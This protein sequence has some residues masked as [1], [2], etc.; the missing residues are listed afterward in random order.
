MIFTY[1]PL[2]SAFFPKV[3]PFE[4]AAHTNDV[5]FC[6]DVLQY[7]AKGKADAKQYMMIWNLNVKATPDYNKSCGIDQWTLPRIEANF[8]LRFISV[9]QIAYKDA[10]IERERAQLNRTVVG[11]TAAFQLD[12][13]PPGCS[14]DLRAKKAVLYEILVVESHHHRRQIQQHE[15]AMFHLP[16]IYVVCWLHCEMRVGEWMIQIVCQDCVSTYDLRFAVDRVAEF[17]RRCHRFF[18]GVGEKA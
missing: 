5:E 12:D 14:D 3:F 8:K 2:S 17:V 1:P 15:T 9:A 4:K 11:P 10:W 7:T 16:A 13:Q 18:S 6:R